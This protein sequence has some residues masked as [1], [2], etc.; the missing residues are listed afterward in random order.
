MQGWQDAQRSLYRSDAIAA[1]GADD[2]LSLADL[3]REKLEL[4]VKV[5]SGSSDQPRAHLIEQAKKIS[6]NS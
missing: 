1:K 2:A 3:E 5:K 4:V 6:S